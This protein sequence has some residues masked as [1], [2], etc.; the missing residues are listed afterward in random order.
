MYPCPRLLPRNPLR[1]AVGSGGETIQR[2]GGLKRDVRATS[3]LPVQPWTQIAIRHTIALELLDHVDALVSQPLAAASGH[4]IR[5]GDRK[6]DAGN[7]GCR[8][9]LGAR[10]CTADMIARLECDHCS[11]ALSSW[12]RHLQCLWLCVS[13]AYRLSSGHTYRDPCGIEND[14]T[15]R[16]IGIGGASNPLAGFYGQ[17]HS[18]GVS[19]RLCGDK[20]RK[21]CH[22]FSPP[23]T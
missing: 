9:C 8:K 23:S 13:P 11:A 12:P 20:I 15:N 5:I 22:R 1:G 18:L 16:W 19:H 17:R 7:T 14:A 21:L 4:G 10:W 2:T 3:P 6:Y